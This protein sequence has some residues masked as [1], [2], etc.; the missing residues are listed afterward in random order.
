LHGGQG[1]FW[2]E[3]GGEEEVGVKSNGLCNHAQ[4][5]PL[6]I[7]ATSQQHDAKRI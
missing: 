5:R 1:G 6:R 2:F 4:E 7:H 3:E